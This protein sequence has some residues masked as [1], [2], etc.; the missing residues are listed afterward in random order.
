MASL[1]IGRASPERAL[2][3]LHQR[4]AGD[5]YRYALAVLGSPAD[6]EDVT[7]ATFINAYRAIQRG[8]RPRQARNWLRAIAHNACREHLRQA[9]RR[10]R[11]V[12]WEEDVGELIADEESP[13]VEDLVRAL[14]LLPYNQRAALVMREFE[15]R[16]LKEIATE[17]EVSV[18]AVETLLFR[19]RR[20]LREQLEGSL[21]C[22]EAEQAISRQLDGALG[23]AER[24]ALRAHLRECQECARFARRV[25]AQRGGLKSLALVPLPTSLASAPLG[26]GAVATG[27]GGGAALAAPLLAK[28]VATALATAVL[29]GVGYED[30]SHRLWPFTQ[31]RTHDQALGKPAHG[32]EGNAPRQPAPGGATTRHI[33]PAA[34]PAAARSPQPKHAT[35]AIKRHVQRTGSG[36]AAKQHD[37]RKAAARSTPHKTKPI[38]SDKPKNPKSSKVTPTPK[39]TSF[40]KPKPKSSRVKPV[41]ITS[42]THRTR[43]PHAPTHGA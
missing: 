38:S 14:K 9:A 19:G 39:A 17:L 30:A 2:E 42:G 22:R 5:V 20:A 21:S 18:S 34:N 26:A 37:R 35:R 8:E 41:K 10:P 25:R 4:Y 13:A 43:Q 29:T 1:L 3:S 28:V 27:A 12:A 23:R 15:G 32:R 40:V 6:A 16:P 24:G 33:A 11:A 31:S 7:Q 36:P